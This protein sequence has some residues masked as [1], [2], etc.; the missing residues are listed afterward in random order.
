MSNVPNQNSL[1][2][3]SRRAST[4]RGRTKKNLSSVFY[5]DWPSSTLDYTERRK[6]MRKKLVTSDFLPLKYAPYIL[7][8]YKQLK[9]KNNSLQREERLRK[10]FFVF[11][12]GLTFL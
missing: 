10:Y 4:E 2:S 11:L 12:C 5:A 6:N 3:A 7:Y 1:G 9:V 8:I